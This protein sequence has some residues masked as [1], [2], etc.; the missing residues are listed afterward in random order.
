M[1]F[2]S[3]TVEV[4]KWIPALAL[5]YILFLQAFLLYVVHLRHRERSQVIVKPDTGNTPRDSKYSDDVIQS[6]AGN[7]RK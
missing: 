1:T 7:E 3:E 4:A 6:G 5:L 2:F